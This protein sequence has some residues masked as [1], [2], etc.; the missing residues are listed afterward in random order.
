[1]EFEYGEHHGG[2]GATRLLSDY[3]RIAEA[4]SQLLDLRLSSV[5]HA[6]AAITGLDI[7]D[8]AYG[9]LSGAARFN[10]AHRCS[11]A[12]AAF[13]VELLGQAL[14]GD[15][16]RLF[17]VAFNHREADRAAATRTRTAEVPR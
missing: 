17:Q 6:H 1:M 15:A 3:P 16:D 2:S 4:A 8:A 7:T 12:D 9:N 14:E 5:E 10:T 13:T 11:V